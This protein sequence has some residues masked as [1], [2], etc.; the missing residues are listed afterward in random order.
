[1]IYCRRGFFACCCTL[2]FYLF[3]LQAAAMADDLS[4]FDQ[5][6]PIDEAWQAI[7]LLSEADKEG[8]QKDHF[9]SET[10]RQAYQDAE[11]DPAI[12][13]ETMSMLSQAL[14]E[15]MK[16]Y[17]NTLRYGQID[18]RQIQENF[19]NP[20]SLDFDPL[21]IL[22]TAI[23]EHN[24]L[25]AV[26]TATPSVPLYA[27]L[28]K[29]LA[30][31]R[32]L[33]GN[34]E[35]SALWIKQLPVNENRK[36][37]PGQT[38]AGVPLISKRLAALGD[39]AHATATSNYTGSVVEG[40]KTFQKRHGLAP[41]GILGSGT[42]ERLNVPPVVRARQIELSM[43]RLRWLPLLQSPRMILVNIPE[44]MLEGYEVRNGQIETKVTMRV[45]TGKAPDMRTPI[46]DEDL[47]FIEFSPYWN[48]PLSIAKSEVVP[49]ILR[50]PGHF[51][52]QGFE[53]VGSDGR[54]VPEATM[55]ALNA[56][57]RGQ[58]RIRQKPGPKNAL[59]DIKFTFPNKDHIY[60]HHTQSV[61]LFK[62]DRR[63]L[64]HGCIRVE[65]PLELAKF[66]LQN[67]PTWPEERIRNAMEKGTS[68]TIRLRDAVRVVIAYNTVLVK[69]DGLV[70]FF[71]DVYGQ[72]NRLDEALRRNAQ[73]NKTVSWLGAK[74]TPQ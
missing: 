60:L 74:L 67:D 20:I 6:K 72:D 46:F 19:S 68:M 22:Q 52:Q 28:R 55:D 25:E 43:E 61:R 21:T 58:M 10:L 47:R 29:A 2:A 16:S 31:Y 27:A 14:T 5:S 56:V 65:E 15:S 30:H 73:E 64:S 23:K 37:E 9:N 8:L 17:L 49:T 35:I 62:K 53:I 54:I 57:L 41:D 26:N 1:M 70:Y 63:D 12:T 42:I 36:I 3:V 40:I 45:I 11:K 18:P 39:M 51:Y 71:H 48:V 59:G 13:P 50:N 24:L 33:A 32:I 66:V 44:S 69:N 38:Y 4:W 7:A 34:P